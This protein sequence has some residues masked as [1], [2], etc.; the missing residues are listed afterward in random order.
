MK[1]SYCIPWN[2]NFSHRYAWPTYLVRDMKKHGKIHKKNKDIH[3]S[4]RLVYIS[5]FFFCLVFD[6]YMDKCKLKTSIIFSK[7][8]EVVNFKW[9]RID[10]L[11]N[12]LMFSSS[13]LLTKTVLSYIINLYIWGKNTGLRRKGLT[14]A[15]TFETPS[16]L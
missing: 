8:C 3:T 10:Q 1:L 9:T 14:R 11:W 13:E 7:E 4:R 16:K 15:F 5:A 12:N 2:S 6:T